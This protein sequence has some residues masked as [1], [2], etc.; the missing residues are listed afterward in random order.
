[1]NG[2]PT[3]L[4]DGVDRFVQAGGVPSVSCRLYREGD[5]TV[6]DVPCVAALREAFT[7]T[8]QAEAVAPGAA[9]SRTFS[10]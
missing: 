6:V 1:M 4:L 8:D 2:S 9:A 5:G 3:F 7:D 10:M